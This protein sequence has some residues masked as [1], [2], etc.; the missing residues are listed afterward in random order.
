[1]FG[2]IKSLFS[3]KIPEETKDTKK[4]KGCLL[5]ISIYTYKC[6]QCGSVN[7]LYDN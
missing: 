1:M 5:R 3:N 6:P 2:F 7:F 4:C